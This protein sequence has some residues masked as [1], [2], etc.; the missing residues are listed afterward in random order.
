M[1]QLAHFLGA[2]SEAG[3]V[4]V[5][6]VAVVVPVLVCVAVVV[7]VDAVRRGGRGGRLWRCR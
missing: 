2:R 5:V 3:A 7:V 6:V 1:P 4:V